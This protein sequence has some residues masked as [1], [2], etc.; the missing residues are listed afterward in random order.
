MNRID[1]PSD[2]KLQ[3]KILDAQ[4]EQQSKKISRGVMGWLLGI[5]DEKP[6]NLVGFSII[7]ACLMIVAL[8]MLPFP[9]DVP[10]R[11]LIMLIAAIIP[12]ALGYYFGFL[13]G[14]KVG[15]DGFRDL[16]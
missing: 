2:R 7:V 13:T 6:G 16:Q 4:H 5:G 14:G 12:G 15:K 3:G 8:G 1:V 10:R 11:E 9:P